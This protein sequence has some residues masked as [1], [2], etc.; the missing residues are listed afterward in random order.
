MSSS[1][2]NHRATRSGLRSQQWQAAVALSIAFGL[3]AGAAVAADKPE[4][5]PGSKP[6]AAKRATPQPA[7][8]PLTPLLTR[9]ELRVCMDLKA[10]N[11]ENGVDV[12]R[13][14]P[15]IAAEKADLLRS[16]E[17]MRAELTVLDRTSADA[18]KDYN[19]RAAARDQQIARLEAKIIEFNAKVNAFEA[20]RETYG[21]DCENRRY[22]EKD[23]KA[24][25]NR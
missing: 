8:R 17:A 21:R 19:D 9:E 3:L 20:G 1:P 25:L 14:Q 18:V 12:Q 24:L 2:S 10:G 13:M 6:P 16:G 22:D 5:R 11:R 4:S 15:E 7:P 23:E